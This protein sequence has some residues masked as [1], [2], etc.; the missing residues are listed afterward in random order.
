MRESFWG[1]HGSLILGGALLAV[2]L[3]IILPGGSGG[4]RTVTHL[5]LDILLTI[6]VFAAALLLLL[7]LSVRTAL[8]LS[9]FPTLILLGSLFRLALCIAAARLI[10]GAT[11]AGTVIELIGALAAGAG[12]AGGGTAAAIMVALVLAIVDLVVI[13]AG[14]GRAAE[15]AARFS[16]D[17]LPGKQLAVD[18]SVAAGALNDAE[19][20]ARRRQLEAEADFYSAMDGASR[21]ARGEAIA[22]VAIIGLCLAGGVV[23]GFMSSGT[24]ELAAT[25]TRQAQ[26]CA[27]LAVVILLPG[28]LSS[29]SAALL[30]TKGAQDLAPAEDV[31]KQ[32][33]LRPGVLWVAAG[34]VVLLAVA[35]SLL[36][37]GLLGALP[38]LIVAGAAI[39]WALWAPRNAEDTQAAD[40]RGPATSIAQQHTPPSGAEIEIHLGLGLVGLLDLDGR[41]GL[42]QKSSSMRTQVADDIGVRLPPIVVR[43]SDELRPCQY[44]FCMRGQEVARGRLMLSKML[45]VDGG[46]GDLGGEPVAARHDELSPMWIEPGSA[47][48]WRAKGFTVFAPQDALLAHFET[49]LRRHAA[50]LIDRQSAQALIRSVQATRPAVAAELERRGVSLGAVRA[51][52][53]ALVDDGLSLSDPVGVLEGIV[54]AAEETALTG[55]GA[56]GAG[57]LAEAVRRRLAPT[58]TASC[59]SSDGSVY[60]LTLGPNAE[61]FVADAL[62]EAP[63]GSLV[64]LP[65]SMAEA[66]TNQIERIRRELIPPGVVPCLVSSP[67]ARRSVSAAVAQACPG[68]RVV[69]WEELLP[70]VQVNHVGPVDVGRTSVPPRVEPERLPGESHGLPQGSR[71]LPGKAP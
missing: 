41:D 30:V 22:C 32:A 23:S 9:S 29:V 62:G 67:E 28:L 2:I 53:A 25:W 19:A 1:R 20:Q 46:S 61:H 49:T 33:G 34:L 3:M 64:P 15:V 69:S 12:S 24:G 54:D 39:L 4:F 52:L 71:A 59:R 5:A 11:D 17:A 21:F 38:A 43:D 16:L 26:L 35:A 51:A 48:Q 7:A 8:S 70:E 50:T 60:A 27:G 36:G 65:P 44:A 56:P 47:S 6:N 63:P 58:I 57:Q 66:L 42:L 40:G 18:S 45:A 13:S 14:A 31:V 10:I 37:A 55:G 68:L